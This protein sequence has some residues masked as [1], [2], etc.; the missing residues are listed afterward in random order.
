VIQQIGF[1]AGAGKL[2][3]IRAALS[4]LRAHPPVRPKTWSHGTAQ[5]QPSGQ[6][7]FHEERRKR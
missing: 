7:Q 5:E 6:T 1:Q 4:S 3:A 2:L